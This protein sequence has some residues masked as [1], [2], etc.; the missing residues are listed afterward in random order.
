MRKYITRNDFILI[1]LL[2]SVSLI[3]TAVLY[4]TGRKG[5]QVCV[6]VDGEY[7]GEYSLDTDRTIEI[8]GYGNTHNTLV[9]ENG[10]AYMSHASCPDKLCI[11]Q[12]KIS[13]AGR[14]IVCLPDRVV[15]SVKGED[16]YDAFTR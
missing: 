4:A 10:Y 8:D 1:A 9:I 3:L 12:G 11:R 14:S 6:Y 2:V 16:E 13:A 5:G 15:V 7:S